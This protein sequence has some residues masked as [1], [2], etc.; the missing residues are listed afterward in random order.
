MML[1]GQVSLGIHLFGRSGEVRG[2]GT[3]ALRGGQIKDRGGAVAQ[4][5]E[6]SCSTNWVSVCG[7]SKT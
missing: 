7:G 1:N 3:G 4:P 6:G 5:G 2:T